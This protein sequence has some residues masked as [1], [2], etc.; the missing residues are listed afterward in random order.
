ML[1]LF[2]LA[3]CEQDGEIISL[4]AFELEKDAVEI[5]VDF[6]TSVDI[7]DGNGIYTVSSDNSAIAKG[8]CEGETLTIT[9]VAEGTAVITVKDELSRLSETVQ[10][11]V[12]GLT[13]SADVQGVAFEDNRTFNILY[14]SGTYTVS[15]E[16]GDVITAFVNSQDK[17]KIDIYGAKIG[18]ATLTITDTGTNHTLTIPMKVCASIE[19]GTGTVSVVV[20]ESQTIDITA[21]S[22]SYSIESGNN[23]IAFGSVDGNV[24]TITGASIGS[25]SVDIKDV[26]TGSRTSATVY[27]TNNVITF[28]YHESGIGNPQT[29]LI[30]APRLYRGDVWFDLNGNGTKDVSE[31]VTV[32]EN[33]FTFIPATENVSLHGKVT[34]FGRAV[35]TGGLSFNIKEADF[36][37]NPDIRTIELNRGSLN[38]LNI[39]GCTQLEKLQISNN[40]Y[41]LMELDLSTNTALKELYCSYYGGLSLDV[42]GLSELEMFLCTYSDDLRTITLGGNTNL[43]ELYCALNPTLESI[44]GLSECVNLTSLRAYSSGL[45]ELDL[46]QNRKLEQVH[47]GGNAFTAP[48]SFAGNEGCLRD[49]SISNCNISSTGVHTILSS[50]PDKSKI[51]TLQLFGNKIE[52][53]DLTAYTAI[54]TI[55]CYYNNITESEALKLMQSLPMRNPG[56]GATIIVADTTNDEDIDARVEYNH[57]S[58]ATVDIAIAKNWTVQCCF[59]LPSAKTTIPY[60]GK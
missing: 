58:K 30:N 1:P 26:V 9:G 24:A 36:S 60:A 3:A 47:V 56:D 59:G 33:E 27:V 6:S 17:S 25:V 34:R 31:A 43:R 13:L 28:K 32:F 4:K 22:G 21:G 29:V 55:E 8:S 35:N 42:S 54:K 38:S 39:D 41:A 2:F 46:S 48:F 15:A 52:T 53:L 49:L 11:T 16:P 19:T 23:A 18:T 10:V 7:F 5:G 37:K 40:S 57:F 44:T 45:T 20:G 50:I 12:K 51:T 14:G